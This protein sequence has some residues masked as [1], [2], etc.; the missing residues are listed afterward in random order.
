MNNLTDFV[1][2]GILVSLEPSG[3]YPKAMVGLFSVNLAP[4]C[5]VGSVSIGQPCKI[6]VTSVLS[7]RGAFYRGK[8]VNPVTQ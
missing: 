8:S 7:P 5:V 6:E 2:S 3:Q 4:D 1:V